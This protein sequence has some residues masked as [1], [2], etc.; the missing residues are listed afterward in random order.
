MLKLAA[1][2]TL[3]LNWPNL[4]IIDT[5]SGQLPFVGTFQL[6][7]RF[8]GADDAVGSYLERCGVGTWSSYL[9][10]YSG[11]EKLFTLAY[12]IFVVAITWILHFSILDIMHY[13][14]GDLHPIW[15]EDDSNIVSPSWL[16]AFMRFSYAIAGWESFVLLIH[17]VEY[18][19]Y[20]LICV[21][22]FRR[23]TYLRNKKVIMP[24]LDFYKRMST[25]FS[26]LSGVPA[27]AFV[28]LNE[29]GVS[30]HMVNLKR[31]SDGILFPELSDAAAK[32]LDG[33]FPTIGSNLKESR[34]PAKTA[35]S[36]IARTLPF[37]YM[38][39]EDGSALGAFTRLG[40]F[41]VTTRHNISH[42]ERG[43]A[44]RIFACAFNK[45]AI[46][47]RTP[48]VDI[49]K[50]ITQGKVCLKSEASE[51]VA[52]FIVDG[53]S[54]D[55]LGISKTKLAKAVRNR[56]P[57]WSYHFDFVKKADGVYITVLRSS[58]EVVP[59]SR[60]ST[61]FHDGDT[62][63]GDCGAP[64]LLR[65]DKNWR[66]VGIHKEGSW[67]KSVIRNGYVPGILVGHFIQVWLRLHRFR[68]NP[69][70][71]YERPTHELP[72]GVSPIKEGSK[73]PG[74]K[75]ENREAREY[76]K[77][78]KY[79]VEDYAEDYYN[80]DQAMDDHYA[81]GAEDDQWDKE[82]VYAS[83]YV[84]KDDT[85]AE[86][87]LTARQEKRLAKAGYTAW[88]DMDISQ[89]KRAMG[90][91]G[92]AWA[93]EDDSDNGYDSDYREGP[94]KTASSAKEQIDPVEPPAIVELFSPQ[95]TVELSE[96]L[97]PVA[98]GPGFRFSA[99]PVSGDQSLAQKEGPIQFVTP[100][101][102]E[103]EEARLRG[104]P[105]KKRVE[106]PVQ[107]VESIVEATEVALTEQFAVKS[108]IA[109]GI[110]YIWEFA[111][112][113]QEVDPTIIQNV[114]ALTVQTFGW[115]SDSDSDDDENAMRASFRMKSQLPWDPLWSRD[116]AGVFE[117]DWKLVLWSLLF[118]FE[119]VSRGISEYREPKEL[120]L[121][122]F[123]MDGD[124]QRL[125]LL[126][127][128]DVKFVSDL[129][130]S[131]VRSSNLWK[132]WAADMFRE[133]P[134][135]LGTLSRM[136]RP[137]KE[138]P[139]RGVRQRKVSFEE[140]ASVEEP[141]QPLES[142]PEE[143]RKKAPT[144]VFPKVGVLRDPKSGSKSAPSTPRTPIIP[145]GPKEAESV[146]EKPKKARRRNRK[147]KGTSAATNSTAAQAEEI[148]P[149][150]EKPALAVSSPGPKEGAGA[151]AALEMRLGV[152][153]R[154]VSSA[155]DPR[156][157]AHYEEQLQKYVQLLG[158][159]K[160]KLKEVK[161][162][163][164]LPEGPKEGPDRVDLEDFRRPPSSN[165]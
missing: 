125:C 129:V 134:T 66:L 1:L 60:L 97:S 86:E 101:P 139:K 12:T 65:D 127:P 90:Q 16:A 150:E 133:H 117:W 78:L 154:N 152:L 21:R 51:D 144:M 46:S 39:A 102:R 93:D 151:D 42:Y 34:N 79:E 7:R 132:S 41:L 11:T 96:D 3:W 35:K 124:S 118:Q 15:C 94:E 119:L 100:S 89:K 99:L 135:Q 115:N 111:Y 5:M 24:N 164:P 120:V 153:V 54:W 87:V 80:G 67:D 9:G 146:S 85:G 165:P 131:I 22:N 126:D 81:Y 10:R 141:K 147:R 136:M 98:F 158:Q 116:V 77:S 68:V 123:V 28:F 159:A 62:T 25:T 122:F 59:G 38:F 8:R 138:G 112:D 73:I 29:N 40:D 83:S 4:V 23:L 57:I 145:P 37:G 6:W 91:G 2:L 36:F 75:S 17:W 71:A 72:P 58:C 18:I 88:D 95:T 76:E 110:E 19:V 156:D 103:I 14:L 105:T 32:D 121:R 74:D 82:D 155:T 104:K 137:I 44:G 114:R 50:I 149:R 109:D 45:G 160:G 63:K 48:R 33:L 113:P 92:G 13:C 55:R 128:A 26:G 61:R 84:V 163:H 64:L 30:K 31:T 43:D 148:A 70:I 130:V 52:I 107:A 108:Y 53:S 106:V 140:P 162:S 56:L 69:Q 20:D 27:G 49:T 157:I 161:R 143:K 142:V 47:P